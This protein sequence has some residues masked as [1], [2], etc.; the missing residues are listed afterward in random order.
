LFLGVS[1]AFAGDWGEVFFLW[2]EDVGPE[3]VDLMFFSN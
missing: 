2:S 3:V 1:L